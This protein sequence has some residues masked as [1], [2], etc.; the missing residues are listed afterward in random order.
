MNLGAI[1][2]PDP[3]IDALSA[4]FKPKLTTFA[5]MQFVDVPGPAKKGSGL[6]ADSLSV[7]GSP[8]AMSSTSRW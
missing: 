7:G 6:D 3:R 2:V 8:E 1:R 5:E 4:I